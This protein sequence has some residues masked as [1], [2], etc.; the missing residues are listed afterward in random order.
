MQQEKQQ[1]KPRRDLA[2][3]KELWFLLFM[4]F[5]TAVHNWMSFWLE[6]DWNIIG[7]GLLFLITYAVF[8]W[9]RL[10][11]AIFRRPLSLV[12]LLGIYIA[13]IAVLGF[14]MIP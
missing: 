11:F 1:Q 2:K 7:Y 10:S 13:G 14:I 8:R 4:L 12:S 9:L 6:E 3:F 5:F